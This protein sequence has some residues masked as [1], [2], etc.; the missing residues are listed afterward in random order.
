MS[1]LS[2]LTKL[3]RVDLLSNGY[4]IMS[5]GKVL[6]TK[7]YKS[8]VRFSIEGVGKQEGSISWHRHPSYSEGI[9]Q[10]YCSCR[11]S[12]KLGEFCEHGMAALLHLS[13]R[14]HDFQSFERSCKNFHFAETGSN[15]S[16]DLS[17]PIN[18]WVWP[19]NQGQSS[20]LKRSDQKLSRI[21]EL[22]KAT[23]PSKYLTDASSLIAKPVEYSPLEIWYQLSDHG[24]RYDG[25][26]EIKLKQRSILT[27]TGKISSRKGFS[28]PINPED[29]C[30]LQFVHHDDRKILKQYANAQSIAAN[31]TRFSRQYEKDDFKTISLK[32]PW[33]F[34]ALEEIAKTG[35]LYFDVESIPHPNST[36][37]RNDRT[38]IVK[39][40]P[41]NLFRWWFI[42]APSEEAPGHY[43]L[44]LAARSA[45]G[46]QYDI[47]DVMWTDFSG[48]LITL[49]G[50]L[51]RTPS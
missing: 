26:I 31:I 47:K 20:N 23:E 46:E 40:R 35:R 12:S 11:D 18:S 10:I 14:H 39:S 3:V 49:K 9:V 1:L 17:E 16:I 37:E 36:N 44:S 7:S 43:K 4:S 28:C 13:L 51:R 6:I 38:I 2:H 45:E 32:D 22:I 19:Y 50:E 15:D 29:F 48:A 24:I 41:D 27:T 30:K 33:T 25:S 21:W 8:S 42:A 34:D 5:N